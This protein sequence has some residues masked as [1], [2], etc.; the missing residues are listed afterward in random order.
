M[1]VLHATYRDEGWRLR[2][3]LLLT[4]GLVVI[5]AIGAWYSGSLALLSDTGH[6][7]TDLLTQLAAYVGLSIASYSPRPGSR[8]TYGLHRV[9]VVVGIVSAAFLLVLCGWIAWEA[10]ERL[11]T[12]Y[13]VLPLPMVIAAL[14][15]LV[16]NAVV[17][18]FLRHAH[19]LST[20]A[21][22]LHALSDMASSLAVVVAG[23]A[24]WWTGAAWIDPVLS[25]VLIGFLLRHTLVLLWEALGIVLEASPRGVSVPQ[26]EEAL[27]QLPGVL[28]VH[29]LHVW[30]IASQE[31]V[32]SAHLVVD[33]SAATATVLEQAHK[34]LQE[35]FGIHHSTLQLES[36]E[37]AQARQCANCC[38]AGR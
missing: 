27:R 25:L 2:R 34:V 23:T 32:L 5:Q 36:S 8:F 19:S 22:Y 11:W 13:S 14:V 33:S 1:A 6:L 37:F 20:R 35:R 18:V 9:E 4:C 28:D 24:L 38:Y 29:D 7:L 26:V 3:A 15:G 16:G 17:V 31:A 30:G 21:A 10:F 12:P